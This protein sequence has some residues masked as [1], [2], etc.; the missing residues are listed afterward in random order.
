MP[1]WQRQRRKR[2]SRPRRAC[3]GLSRCRAEPRR[4][5]QIESWHR[6]QRVVLNMQPRGADQEPDEMHGKGLKNDVF[7]IQMFQKQA[8]RSL[9]LH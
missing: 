1:E 4:S 5:E 3:T 2:V 8:S 9:L 6:E 7:I